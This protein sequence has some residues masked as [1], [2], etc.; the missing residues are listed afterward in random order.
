MHVQRFLITISRKVFATSAFLLRRVNKISK[1]CV[2][3]RDFP[4]F[5]KYAL[6]SKVFCK[7]L[8]NERRYRN[9]CYEITTWE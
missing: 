4:E 3:I 2:K 9:Y 5:V 8:T 6:T 1:P 7:Y